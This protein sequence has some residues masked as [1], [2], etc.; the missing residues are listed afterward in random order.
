MGYLIEV[1]GEVPVAG[2]IVKIGTVSE[3]EVQK[4]N[5]T[6]V[7]PHKCERLKLST[8]VHTANQGG[9]AQIC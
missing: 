1:H 8:G 3:E 7:A 2:P 4:E 9:R 6:C 5:N